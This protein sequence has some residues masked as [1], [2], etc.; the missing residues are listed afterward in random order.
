MNQPTPTDEA[1][2]EMMRALAHPARISI[3]RF[4]AAQQSKC[5]CNDVTGCLSLAQ[6]TVSQHIKVLLDAGLILREQQ[7][8][9]NCYT[10]DADRLTALEGAFGSY[11]KSFNLSDTSGQADD[12]E[13]S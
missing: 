7:G 6:S 9:R 2:A 5:C 1:L 10:I 13:S 8:T 12:K 4:L 11:L 3:L